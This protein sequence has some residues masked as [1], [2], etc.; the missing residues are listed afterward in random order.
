MRRLESKK[1][2]L[3]KPEKQNLNLYGLKK[4]WKLS[5]YG[6]R[7]KVGNARKL[8]RK[9]RKARKAEFEPLRVVRKLECELLRA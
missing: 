9:I 2:R 3:G 7:G 1:G 4:S 8:A 6:L 5:R